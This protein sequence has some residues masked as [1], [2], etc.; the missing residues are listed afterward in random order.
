[1][2]LP[3]SSSSREPTTG[4]LCSFFGGVQKLM[5]I[6]F[7][8]L[9]ELFLSSSSVSFFLPWAEFFFFR[10]QFPGVRDPC[11]GS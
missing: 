8:P 1:M 4:I 11:N 5:Q 7:L 2:A 10:L 9:V 3:V 6:Q